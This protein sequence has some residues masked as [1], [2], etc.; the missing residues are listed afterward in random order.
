MTA[1]A[2]PLDWIGVNN[3]SRMLVR[4]NPSGGDPLEVRAPEGRLTEMGWEVYP[5]GLYELLTRI[6]REYAP[7]VVYVSENGAA[8]AD[9]RGHDGRVRDPERIEYLDGYLDAV[10]R[11]I[12]E[13]VPV[14][15]YFVWSLLDNFEWSLGYNPRFGLVYVDY[16]TLERVPKDSFYWYRDRIALR[17]S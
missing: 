6:H 12:A 7:P 8:F 13:G 11:A 9:V 3:Y 1:L 2:P 4:A 10:G 16:P 5:D 15:G 17:S 14:R